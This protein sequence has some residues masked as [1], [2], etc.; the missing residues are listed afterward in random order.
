MEPYHWICPVPVNDYLQEHY[1]DISSCIVSGNKLT[2]EGDY[3]GTINAITFSTNNGI[4]S[5]YTEKDRHGEIVYQ[6]RLTG[7]DTISGYDIS[8]ILLAISFIGIALVILSRKVLSYGTKKN[9][10]I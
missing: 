4:M 8:F 5:S 10:G 2:W 6:L 1:G 3:P 9:I 7:S